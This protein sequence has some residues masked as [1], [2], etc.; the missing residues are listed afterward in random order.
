MAAKLVDAAELAG[1]TVTPKNI[2]VFVLQSARDGRRLFN[3][4]GRDVLNPI[5]RMSGAIT[6]M[7]ADP[8]LQG[9]DDQEDTTLHDVLAATGEGPDV[10][11]GRNL[12]GEK[13]MGGLE[14]RKAMIAHH[15]AAG[16]PVTETA[17]EIGV[18]P[19]RIV[20]IKREIGADIRTGHQ[21]LDT[22]AGRQFLAE[23][24]TTRLDR[25]GQ[26]IVQGGDAQTIR[27]FEQQIIKAC[28]PFPQPI[29]PIPIESIN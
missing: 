11:A 28:K 17:S 4:H 18:S 22:G 10:A 6:L 2:V 21:F 3:A 14:G 1:K 15:V 13:L 7:Y 16:M 8:P 5:A 29:T 26:R 23:K 12:D 19:A 20:R 9:L 24:V 27:P 25:F